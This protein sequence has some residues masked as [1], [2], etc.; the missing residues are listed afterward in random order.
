MIPSWL[1]DFTPRFCFVGTGKVKTSKKRMFWSWMYSLFWYFCLYQINA[2]FLLNTI[3]HY[4]GLAKRKSERKEPQILTYRILYCTQTTKMKMLLLIVEKI[5]PHRKSC[6]TL[7][8]MAYDTEQFETLI[9]S[10]TLEETQVFYLRKSVSIHKKHMMRFGPTCEKKCV[11]KHICHCFNVLCV[12][13]LHIA[14]RSTGNFGVFQGCTLQGVTHQLLILNIREK[15]RVRESEH[16]GL[17]HLN[18]PSHTIHIRWK[19]IPTLN[20][21]CL[22]LRVL[23]KDCICS[24]RLLHISGVHFMW[25]NT[26][27]YIYKHK[28]HTLANF[29]ASWSS[30]DSFT[31]HKLLR[32]WSPAQLILHFNTLSCKSSSQTPN[33]SFKTH[34]VS[35]VVVLDTEFVLETPSTETNVIRDSEKDKLNNKIK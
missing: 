12:V 4:R 2:T 27:G 6:K 26:H 1:S 31:A 9:S 20:L 19:N 15:E 13:A 18:T 30:S 29:P 34:P 25:Q 21:F 8:L 5:H 32:L 14:E 3:T 10:E 11:F 35:N 17:S 28:N 22:L 16:R 23:K 24:W 7:L 33:H